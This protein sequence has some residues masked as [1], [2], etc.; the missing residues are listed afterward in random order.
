MIKTGSTLSGLD[1]LPFT[2]DPLV[3][4]TQPPS[5]VT[6][7]APFSVVV[8]ATNAD[9]TTNTTFNGAVTAYDYDGYSLGG[10]VTVNAVNGIATFNGL[11][12]TNAYPYGDYLEFYNS[13]I[14]SVYTQSFTVVPGAATKLVVDTAPTSVV[15]NSS[16]AASFGAEDQY[17]NIDPTYSGNVTLALGANPGKATLSGTVT[18]AAA[19]GVASFSGITINKLGTGDTLIASAT[20]LAGGSSGTFNAT[21]ELV[22]TTPPPANVTAGAPFTVVVKAED[23]KGTIDTSFT[24]SI[25]VSDYS[26]SLGGSLTVNAINGVATFTGLTLKEADSYEE[27]MFNSTGMPTVYSQYFNV[28]A[29]AA[30]KLATDWYS[31][32]TYV[33]NSPFS[34]YVDAY[35]A[36]GNMATSFTG[37]VTVALGA[38]PTGATIGGTLTVSAVN[39]TANFSNILISR[40]GAGYTLVSSST[41]LTSVTSTTFNVV[42]QLVVTTQPPSSVTAG[43]PFTV[44]VSAED[45]NGVIDTSFTGTVTVSDYDYNPL[46]GT[47]TVNVVNGVATFSNLTLVTT[48]PSDQL[49]FASN[50]LPSVSSN[51][52]AVAALSPTQLKISGPN[53]TGSGNDV[54]SPFAVDVSVL[55]KFGNVATNFNGAITISLS[56]NPGGAT[57][58][59]TMTINAVNGEATFSD[60]SVNK[61]GNGYLLQVTSSGLTSAV[62][63]PF[64][65]V[66]QLVV[67]T[68]P[69]ANVTAGAP[70]GFVVEAE[71]G[72]GNLDTS[73]NGD[74]TVRL[75]NFAGGDTGVGGRLTVQAINGIATFSG[76]TINQA[77]TVAVLVSSNSIEG[78]YAQF[79]VVA[80]AFT[81]LVVTTPT[82]ASVT[83]NAP[84]GFSVSVEDTYGNVDSTFNGNVTVSLGTNPGAASLGGTVT[85]AAVNGAA[86]FTNLTVNKAGVGYRLIAS[87]TNL[88]PANTGTFN[89]LVAGSATQF[90]IMSAVPS[91]IT[92]GAMFGLVVKAVDD[93]GAV[94]T[95]FNGTVTLSDNL[96]NVL[97][98]SLSV[99]A[100]KGVATFTGLTADTACSGDSL[101]ASNGLLSVSTNLFNVVA[102]TATKLVVASPMANVLANVAFPFQINA[103]DSF[104][105]IDS[106]F[107]GNVTVAFANNPAAGV[108]TGTLTIQAVN[109]VARFTGITISKPGT[110][111]TLQVTST[112]LTAGTT[113][114]FNV[115]NDQLVVTSP[116]SGNLTAGGSFGLT[117]TAKNGSGTLDNSF[118]GAITLNL[119]DF[120]GTGATLTGTVTATAVNGVATFSNLSLDQAGDFAI[121]ISSSTAVPT[122]TSLFSVLPAPVQMQF[123]VD[124]QLKFNPQIPT[125]AVGAPFS[126]SVSVV[127]GYGDVDSSYNGNVTLALG[128]NPGNATLGGT[129]TV[130]ATNGVANFSGLTLNKLGT[131]YTLTATNAN[132]PSITTTAFN[133]TAS[134][135]GTQLIV[136]SAPPAT[137][138]AGA[139]FGLVVKAEDAFGVVET[140]FNGSVTLTDGMG[141]TIGG[142]LTVQAVN[143]VATFS[144][145]SEN[146]AVAD[147]TLT[148]T[149]GGVSATTTSYTVI[150]G[151]ATAIE[152]FSPSVNVLPTVP[153][154]LE[155][156]AV[157]PFGNPDP[158]FS[159]NITLALANNPGSSTLGGTLTVQAVNGIANFSGLTINKPG[160]GYSL[161]ATSTA[162]PKG[163]SSSFNVTNDQLVVT[164]QVQ[165]TIH[166]GTTFGFAVSAENGSG[167][168]DKSFKGNVTLTLLD[169]DGTGAKLG[170]TLTATAVNGV[171]TFTNLN[172]AKQGTYGIMGSGTGIGLTVTDPFSISGV[173]TNPATQLAFQSVPVTTTAGAPLTALIVAVKDASG[174]VVTTDTST[175]T[176]SVIS[177]PG[178]FAPNSVLT[179]TAI[180]GVA[181]FNNLILDTSGTYTFGVTDGK[182]TSAVSGNVTVNAAAA[183]KL[184]L[185]QVPTTGV[186]GVALNP[187]IKVAIEDTFGNVL[188]GNTSNVTVALNS[189]PTGALFAS[190]STLTVAAVAGVATFSNLVLKTAGVYTLKVT[191]G[192]L[193]SATSGNITVGAAAAA[194]A[195]VLAS[196]ITVTAGVAFTTVTVGVEDQFGNFVQSA[197]TV[198]LTLASGLFSTGLSTVTAT[199]STGV[200][201]F[202][203]LIINTTGTYTIN[204][205]D[206]ALTGSSFSVTVTP[207]A[208]SKLV[209]QQVPTTGVA[210]VALNPAIKVVI[211]DAFGNIVIGNTSNVT[212][213]LNSAPTGAQFATGSTLTVAAVAGVATFSNLVLK[214]AGVYTLKVTDGT[215][216]SATSGNFTVGAAAA[217]KTVVLA[218]PTSATAGVAFTA[219]T[220]GVEDQYGNLVQTAQTV[221]LTLASG[222][223]STG[224][225]TVTA[226]TTGGVATFSS[227]I[228]NTSGTYTINVSDGTLT[229]SSFSVTVNAAAANKLVLQQVPT[230]GVAGVALNPAIKVAIEDTFGNVLIGNTSN[231][232]VA[233]NSGPTG[234]LFATGSTLTVAAVAGVATFSNLV[235]KTAGVYTLKVTDGTLTSATSGNITVGAAAAAKTVVLA[236]PTS[237]TAGVAFTAVTV[238]VEDQ[239]RNLVQTAQTVKLTLASGLFSTGLSTVTA[240]TTAGVATFSSLIINTSGTYTINVSDGTL[241]GSSISVTINPAAASKLVFQQVPT[242]GVAGVAFNPAIKVVIEDA[243]G[244]IVIGNTSNVTIALNSAP[245]G[246]QFATGSTLTVAAVAGVAT[247]SNLVLKTAGVYTLKVTDGTLTS[248]TSGN[249]TVVAGAAAKTV[250][251]ASPTSAT[252]GVAF[253]AVTVG[254]E[255]T[256][257]NLIQSAQTVK[258]TLA[259]GL[260]STGLSTVTATTTAGVATF[261]SLIINTSG[262]YTI[263]VSDGTLTGSSFIVTVNAAAASKLIFTTV[264]STGSLTNGLANPVTVSVEDQFG[265]VVVGNTST[266]TL[267]ISSG[268]S[269]GAFSSGTSITLVAVSGVA[270]FS[271]VKFTKA[272]TYQ[273]KATGGTLTVA[274]SGNIVIS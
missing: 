188:I 144:G 129:V 157:D 41:G 192:S 124:D 89:V 12:I 17:G 142:T 9:G 30:T 210:G 117:V 34:F 67:T 140:A 216:T 189:G 168:V 190:G 164:T 97:G 130:A 53:G 176:L 70:F 200:A 249:I 224:L 272:G 263:N 74:V 141:N 7:G 78:T 82:P 1:L 177:G 138:T 206:G 102:G 262:T 40:P 60:L 25:T 146:A 258:L 208:P 20:G 125:V 147:D 179:A 237:A 132:F 56:N 156:A 211:E 120:D 27:L 47:T 80:A 26:Q 201:T 172:L 29:G 175:V 119:L 226:T 185:Q 57:L 178:N 118:N 273:L 260:F 59:G 215:L 115:T 100:V 134:G 163:S 205:S 21:D 116:V 23:G 105:N 33:A 8:T 252:A 37:N 36:Y 202:S 257:G 106:T 50:G 239:Y 145:L 169:Y 133:V 265:N 158:T 136:T 230:T 227:L 62:S 39:G 49:Y 233:L 269:G 123:N 66:E 187:A 246:A 203:S 248:A 64:D 85:V 101:T 256:Y 11:T 170:G 87:S 238:G 113:S 259:S 159:G 5:K 160:N 92:A 110:G 212:I 2:H 108:L 58:G 241:A 270:T 181:T 245:T 213:A 4:T 225:S 127:D 63:V 72:Q 61:P 131:G 52:F 91:N 28:I 24:G 143:G 32:G 243:F 135:L 250:V 161:S 267:T 43:V 38:D 51:T 184:V 254:V 10:T 214:T 209:L 84:F 264:P 154:N 236:S 207:A 204:V 55:D 99:Q 126:A 242:T 68:P 150:A 76:L 253:T 107:N 218:S 18:V 111:Y 71:L 95:T 219:V 109:G 90:K 194:K 15:V 223:F 35:D 65:V 235:L 171:A 247:F 220:I 16:F 148:A 83:I 19:N 103:E 153:F 193:T 73:F 266:V 274:V 261:S 42:D 183:N 96:G 112:G 98:G 199:T 31:Y 155:V 88:T 14:G 128:A 152:V 165:P 94:D 174:N 240:T 268:P 162:L 44:A 173:T 234:A 75:S 137:L 77:G 69:P 166:V 251:L 197:Q 151:K 93:L 104:G 228:I 198:K 244:N 139:G 180:A 149:S 22:V 79:N 232:T 3:V 196:P 195:V 167:T 217:A 221:K 121:A 271:N 191:D 186:A 6:A 13:N 86:T 81:N 122:T 46:G 114:S 231:V 48:D 45:G 54:A 222:L 229:G 255:D 182:L